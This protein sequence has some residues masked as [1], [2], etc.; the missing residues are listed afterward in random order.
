MNKRNLTFG[1]A[2]DYALQGQL[3]ARENW[4]GKGQFVFIRPEDSIP[5]HVVINTVKSLPKAVKDYYIKV[6]A[7]NSH[8]KIE[9]AEG[10]APVSDSVK[11]SQ[12]FCLK[13]VDDNITNGWVAS[14]TDLLAKDWYVVEI[15]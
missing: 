11:F 2:T 7:M 12:Y 6:A 10:Q 13:T 5:F 9:E 4:N 1:E 3:I 14:Q 15:D 8:N